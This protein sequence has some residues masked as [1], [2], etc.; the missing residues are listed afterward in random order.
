MVGRSIRIGTIAGIP[1]GVQPAWLFIFGLVTWILAIGW[2]PDQVSGISP[3]A[4]WGLGLA[5]ALLLFAGIVAHEYGHAIVARRRGIEVE[6]I[7]LWLLGG[8]ARMRGHAR[9]PG[10]ELAYAAAGPAVTLVLALIFSGIT[11]ALPSGSAGRA[12]AQYEAVTSILILAF[13]LLPALPLDG[14]RVLR[15]ALWRIGGDPIKATMRAAA[16]GRI[17]AIALMGLGIAAVA[18][19]SLGGLWIV[20]VGWFLLS[21]AT[22]ERIGAEAQARMSGI[23]AA[24][25]MTTPAVCLPATATAAEAARVMLREPHPA[26]PVLENGRVVGMLSSGAIANLAPA[27]RNEV[28]IASLAD[29]D[30]HLLLDGEAEVT[31]LLEDPAFQ[32]VQR[33]TVVDADGHA[34]GVLSITDVQRR[35]DAQ[36]EVGELAAPPT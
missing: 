18:L 9:K 27:S 4:A 13:N 24:E 14:G 7:D 23:H 8:V 16:L 33:A 15:A 12:L 11:L 5:G 29:R 30:P 17:F 3:E 31:T 1:F 20:L 21:A 26:F 28:L 2:F 32:R 10:D 34:L 25:L 22:S 6:E 35:F 19:G 36:R